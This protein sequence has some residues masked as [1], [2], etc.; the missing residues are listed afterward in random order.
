LSSWHLNLATRIILGGGVIA[1]PTEAVYGLGCLPH[2]YFAV[3]RI[4]NLKNRP[5]KKG[6]ILVAANI[7]QLAGYIEFPHETVRQRVLSTWP[8]PVTWVLPARPEV[9]IWLRGQ[10]NTI[11]ARVSKHEVIRSLCEKTGALVSTSANP[12]N[13]PPA[14]SALKVRIYFGQSLDYILH[15]SIGSNRQ[16]TEIR[17]AY[18]GKILRPGG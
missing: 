3:A 18:T 12:A 16:P 17:E 10:H 14:K 4:L 5:V 2:D 7:E 13:R 6:L 8:G 11:A 15:A 1:Y 9:P